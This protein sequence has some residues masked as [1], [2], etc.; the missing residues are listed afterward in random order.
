MKFL[1]IQSNIK[2]AISYI[3]RAVG[4]NSNLPILKNAF[5]KAEGAMVSFI[6]TNLE[7]ATTYHVVG[8]VL[9]EGLITVPMGILSSVVGNIKSDRLNFETKGNI[10]EVKTDNYSATI[11]GSSADDF[12]PTPKVKNLESYI[13]VKG[14]LLREAIAEVCAAAQLSDLRPELS[15]VLF[16]FSIETLKLAATDGFRLAEKT[17]PA[18]SLTVKN[19]ESFK[20]LVPLKTSFEILRIVKDEDVVRICYDENQVLF[21]TERAEVISRLI[22]GNFPEYAQIVPKKFISEIVVNLAEFTNGVKL[23][24]VFGQKNSEIEI[25]VHPNKKAIEILSADQAI[26]EN[27]YLLPAKIKGESVSVIFNWRYLA[28][29][30]KVLNAEEI[31]LGF[32]EEA[33]PALIRPASD[34]SYF[35]VIKP[36]LRA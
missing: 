4:E 7:I 27:T 8:K 6:A 21:K 31:Q 3:E 34:A 24:S 36:I 33:N 9:E 18:S 15:S 26:G 20:M 5:I 22:E 30:L 11:Q 29:P 12:P 14:I 35:Y 23:A 32:Q 28:D 2:E 16:N 10:L 19:Q 1:A 25:R 13:E 17:I